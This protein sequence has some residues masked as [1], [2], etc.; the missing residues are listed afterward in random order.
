MICLVE[1]LKADCCTNC[2]R[3][4]LAVGDLRDEKDF[5]IDRAAVVRN[6]LTVG[7]VSDRLR[8]Q[9]L[10]VKGVPAVE[11]SRQHSQRSGEL[12]FEVKVPWM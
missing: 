11:A 2:L 8:Q 10:A 12:R 7:T 1:D 6:I 3:G 5:G 4:A 9:R